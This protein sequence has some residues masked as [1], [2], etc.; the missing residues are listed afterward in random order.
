MLRVKTIV[1]EIPGKGLGLFA[2][3]DI[4]AGTVT[5]QYDEML[6]PSYT[7]NQVASMTEVAREWFMVYAYFDHS[8]SRYVLCADNERFINHSENPNIKATPDDEVAARDIKRGEE[9]TNDYTDYEH[10]WFE[11]RGLDRKSFL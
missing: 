10:D 4:P 7:E 1:K 5:W 2:D 3:Q 11:R 6:D 9:M 8:R